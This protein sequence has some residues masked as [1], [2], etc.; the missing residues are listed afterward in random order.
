MQKASV[1]IFNP[2][3]KQWQLLLMLCCITLVVHGQSDPHIDR[4]AL[5]QRHTVHNTIADSLSSLSVGN[6]AFAYTADITGM[7]SF[8]DI[9]PT[10]F[11]WAHN[12][13]GVGIVFLI[14]I[15]IVLKKR[16]SITS[17][18]AAAYRI[19]CR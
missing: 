9:M 16:S 6:G 15:T 10:V 1:N 19:P 14:A 13:A 3:R 4:H 7:Q 17:C 12:L 2:L 8:P 5:V 18:R 11:H